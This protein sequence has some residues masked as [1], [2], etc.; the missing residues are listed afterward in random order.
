MIE[1]VLPLSSE[2]MS[3]AHF[4][5]SAALLDA[6]PT[7]VWVLD[8]TGRC[9]FSNA[10]SKVFSGIDSME[11]ERDEWMGSFHPDEQA[12]ASADAGA[13][14]ASGTAF[15]HEY[16]IRRHD[17]VYRWMSVCATPMR[18]PAGEFI[19][20]IGISH[21]VTERRKK[22][23]AL[24]AA[25]Q[26]VEDLGRL[27]RDA[28]WSVD[29]EQG[30]VTHSA[31]MI[32]QYGAA[33][34][35]Y[36]ASFDWWCRIVHPEDIGRVR[37]AFEDA[38]AAGAANVHYE[39]RIRRLDGSYAHVDDRIHILRD[40]GGKLIRALG[41]MRDITQRRV[42]QEAQARLTRILEAS[43]DFVG[44]ATP[45]GRV[46]YLNPAARRFIGYAAD[47]P[48]ADTHISTVHPAWAF[49]IVEKEGIPAAIRDGKWMGESAIAGM[50]G[51]ETPVSQLIIAH[52]D[53][54]GHVE[55]LSTVM[56]DISERKREE[57]ARM[58][59]A[60][61]YDAAIRASGQL[62]F[63]WD[64]STG[65]ITYAGD[66]QH[67]LG[68]SVTEMTGGLD[69]FRQL[70]H[71]DDLRGFD[72]QIEQVIVTRD[73]FRHDFRLRRK[74]GREIVIA[75]NGYFFMD[76]Q[77]RIG[78]MVGFFADVTAQQAAEA[79]L[80][81]AH[82]NLEERV[83]QRTAELG[84]AN[85]ELE[86]RAMQQEA[87]AT[88]GQRALTGA[89]LRVLLDEAAALVRL[90]M[91]VDYCSI[92]EVTAEGSELLC[93]AEAGWPDPSHSSVPAGHDSQS[94]YT[95]LVRCPVIMEDSLTETRF[96]IS[97]E[98]RV[99]RARSGVTVVIESGSQPIGV[100]AV[101]TVEQ[102][103]F[104]Q[105]DVN[106]LLSAANVLTAAIDR[107]R[108]EESVSHAREQAES[109][110]RAKSEFLSRMSHELRTPLNAILGFTQL[111]EVDRPSPSQTESIEHISRAGKHLLAL[112]NEVLDISRIETG[113]LALAP[114]AVEISAFL[115][116]S[117]D[118]IRPLAARLGIEAH[119]GIGCARPDYVFAD[120][121]RLKQVF[122]NLLSNAVKYNRP[123]GSV[124]VNC[125]P[126]Q[127]GRL[128]IDVSDT[129]LGISKDKLA[130]LFLPFERLGAESSDVEGTGIGL[131][132]SRGIVTALD[133]EL[134]VNSEE[135]K[136]ST[137]WVLLPIADAPP[138]V[139]ALEPAKAA[140]PAPVE[141][142]RAPRTLLYI[143]DE[144]LNL[145]LVQ[146]ILQSH[147][148]YRLLTA[149]QGGL[150]LELAREH[151]PDLILLDLNLPDMTGE[152]V[153]RRL[154]G[155]AATGHIPVLMVSADAMG[156]RIEEILLLGACGYLT[157]P[158]KVVQ[159]LSVIEETLA[160]KP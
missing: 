105:D 16:R 8:A 151:Q 109:A 11:R 158:Y 40:A 89:E 157:K 152:E 100:L 95:L 145:R 84:H 32:A 22:D 15:S 134:G 111:L 10:A 27:T 154:K 136:G 96:K 87:V 77:G 88:L 6:L 19:G 156:D 153:L 67:F 142:V 70:V 101:F 135:G 35:E 38:L 13:A 94:G 125:A 55:F 133:G 124:T 25:E 51:R 33:P 115:R 73:P 23:E 30:R 53:A 1:A 50:E 20:F 155:D 48:I 103:S 97:P 34:E 80:A 56:H 128:R 28:V 104:T 61:R 62:L 131:A 92:L 63:D 150:G 91:R 24:S 4:G 9:I 59:W 107:K 3:L 130:R 12:R 36:D 74:D 119:L 117:L 60:N 76:R 143:E 72:E 85:L 116:E 123:G 41:A 137:F 46:T 160:G 146:R 26:E 148:E 31:E 113:R 81:R 69:R 45:D 17:G 47:D 149:M 57:I 144:D 141:P 110:N 68:Y 2:P 99:S 139:A 5:T 18:D 127:G 21:D 39:Y 58:E 7:I 78:R 14:F 86:D 65:E 71:P 102:R 29:F 75:A 147:P 129:G 90:T 98:A 44:I 106:F 122:L 83:K 66:L 52:R 49:E 42:A 138:E 126:A 43:N 93:I 82:D 108:A 64:S 79:A 121:L 140:P 132:L 37:S 54:R 114:E 159:F 112:I 118:L 120:R